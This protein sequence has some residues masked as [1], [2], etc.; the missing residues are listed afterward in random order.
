VDYNNNN[1]NNNNNSNASFSVAQNKPPSASV[2]LA[3]VQ[4]GISSLMA[5][6]QKSASGA[7]P[8]NLRWIVVF[9]D[10]DS[11]VLNWLET[12]MTTVLV[13]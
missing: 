12:S 1:T 11:D 9:C 4:T 2:A 5:N 7:S 6:W 13:R 10:I 8:A 3:T